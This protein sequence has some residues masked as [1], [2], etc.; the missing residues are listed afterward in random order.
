MKAKHIFFFTTDVGH[1]ERAD[2][3]IV[4]F[5]F[6]LMPIPGNTYRELHYEPLSVENIVSN[7]L[8]SCL[9]FIYQKKSSAQN[10]CPRR[11]TSAILAFLK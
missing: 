8:S 6:R 2:I 1:R 7:I 4:I 3:R 5:R 10:N 11:D 9:I